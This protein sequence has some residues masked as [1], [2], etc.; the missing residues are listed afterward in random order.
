MFP[1]IIFG[2]IMQ[3]EQSFSLANYTAR[4]KKRKSMYAV[5]FTQTIAQP[6]CL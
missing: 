1:F 6:F 3:P 4:P 5:L 2:F